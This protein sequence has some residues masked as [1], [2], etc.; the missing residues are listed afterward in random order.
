MGSRCTEDLGGSG[1]GV[2]ASCLVEEEMA[3]TIV[4]F[5]LG[6]IADPV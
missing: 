3:K 2:L 5:S 4:P 1:L 6:Y